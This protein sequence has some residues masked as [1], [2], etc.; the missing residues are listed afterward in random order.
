MKPGLVLAKIKEDKSGILLKTFLGLEAKMIQPI[1]R[2]RFLSTL[3]NLDRRNAV[4]YY[5][6]NTECKVEDI[7][8][9]L[10]KHG[11]SY[12]VKQLN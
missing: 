6:D 12:K 11:I 1:N 8:E 9:L 7:F 2:G 3:N 5:Q 4:L 10:N